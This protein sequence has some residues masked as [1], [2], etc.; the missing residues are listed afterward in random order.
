[1]DAVFSSDSRIARYLWHNKVWSIEYPDIFGL[2]NRNGDG[3]PHPLLEWTLHPLTPVLFATVYLLT[4]SYFNRSRPCTPSFHIPRSLIV[5]HNALLAIY[6]FATFCKTAPLVYGSFIKAF[7]YHGSQGFVRT[8]CDMDGR[9]WAEG[10]NNWSYVFYLSKYY[11]VIDTI[12][13]LVKGK[14]AHVL[15][16]Y[17]HAGA[18]ITM[19]AALSFIHTI[20][21]TYYALST[22]KVNVPLVLKRSLTTMQITQFLV[23]FGNSRLLPL[24]P[25][26]PRRSVRPSIRRRQCLASDGQKLATVLNLAYLTPL[27][28]LFSN[29]FI[30]SYTKRG[31]RHA[32]KSVKH[33]RR[34]RMADNTRRRGGQ[35]H[36]AKDKDRTPLLEEETGFGRKGR[37]WFW[38]RA[39]RIVEKLKEGKRESSA[40]NSAL[41]KSKRP[42]AERRISRSKSFRPLADWIGK[43]GKSEE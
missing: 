29:F 41:K 17:H 4:V 25:H 22:M 37:R 8:Y 27:T 3:A 23:G 20:M 33:R 6:S 10:L 26:P 16:E 19:W 43:K 5:A 31:R 40:K 24:H 42:V 7:W 28:V 38:R 11:E 14:K 2:V 30:K 39:P 36:C 35:L 1:M 13:I 32:P 9:I 21:Y 15:Q 18:I 34:V 12:I